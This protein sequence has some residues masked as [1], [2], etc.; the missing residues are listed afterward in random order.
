MS[1]QRF[2]WG[3]T[4]VLLGAVYA[5]G[6]VTAFIVSVGHGAPVLIVGPVMIIFSSTGLVAA[7]CA[8]MRDEGQ[9][10]AW[11]LVSSSFAWLLGTL[12]L[13]MIPGGKTTF[14]APADATRLLFVVALIAASYCFPIRASTPLDR[15]INTFD[16]LTIVAG[17]SMTLWYLL[18]GPALAIRGA[19]PAAAAIYAIADL[20][21]LFGFV[22]VLLRGVEG[23]DRRPVWLLAS[24]VLPLTASDAFLSYSQAHQSSSS[25]TSFGQLACITTMTFLMAAASVERCRDLSQA[26]PSRLGPPPIASMLPYLAVAAGW[27]LMIVAASKEQLFPWTGLVS[28]GLAITGFVVLRQISVQQASEAVAATDGLTGI[29]N[30]SH[31]NMLLARALKR[32]ARTGQVVAVLLIDMNGFKQVNDR[33]GHK[34]G[35]HLLVVFSAMLRSSI[36]P[37]DVA[38]RL[39][40]DEFALI[41]HDVASLEDTDLVLRRLS[42]AS[43]EPVMI[44]GVGV[45]AS[46]SIGIALS[47]PEELTAD[48]IL[49]RADLAM[50]EAKRGTGQIRW[51]YWATTSGTSGS[52]MLDDERTTTLT[53]A[54]VTERFYHVDG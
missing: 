23:A 25:R 2:P 40:G 37:P 6:L 49:H 33:L 32:A 21:L 8:S 13:F 47:H 52:S 19:E 20:V 28:G 16:G 50:Y 51:N 46:A 22:R 4:L 29:T 7:V 17:A 15:R 12:I 18:V 24:A 26:P 53:S 48:E 42:A 34:A 5:G 30:R 41:L 39:G 11:R 3:V 1:R 54:P 14:P 38:G 31:F 45:R 36:R 44:D 43:A 35:D 10:R 27:T 9:R